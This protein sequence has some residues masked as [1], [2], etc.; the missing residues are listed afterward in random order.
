LNLVK[1]AY[2]LKGNFKDL[3]SLA[4]NAGFGKVS[5]ILFDLGTHLPSLRNS[6]V[7]LSKG[8]YAGYAFGCKS[9]CQGFGCDNGFSEK[10][11]LIYLFF[12]G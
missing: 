3:E 10:D 4:I 12:M 8:L 2:F 5:G 7:E 11:L 9:W 1:N 6:G